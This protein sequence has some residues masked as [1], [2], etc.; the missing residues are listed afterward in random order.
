MIRRTSSPLLTL[1]GNGSR[2]T[3]SSHAYLCEWF[4]SLERNRTLVMP[5]MIGAEETVMGVKGQFIACW[6]FLGVKALSI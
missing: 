1:K 6:K 5:S 4:A 2:S 3:V